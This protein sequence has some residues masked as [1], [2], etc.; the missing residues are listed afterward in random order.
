L[1]KLSSISQDARRQLGIA[2]ALITVIPALSIFY[3][4]FASQGNRNPAAP[5]LVMGIMSASIVL[6]YFLVTKYRDNLE[7]M[8][9]ERT[10]ELQAIND[11]LQLEVEERR[12]VERLKD[13]FVSTV[14]HELRTPLAI[15]R[16]GVSLLIDGIPGPINEKQAKVLT[17]AKGN[18]DRLTRIINDLLDISKIEAGRMDIKHER[19]GVDKLI[20]H[21]RVSL[22]PLAKQ[23]GLR[24]EVHVPEESVEVF[25]DED[26]LVQV[27]N[28]LISNAIKFTKEGGVTVSVSVDD[29][30]MR[31]VIEDT[32]TGISEDDM[33]RLFHKFVQI[34]R[35]HGAG[36]KG[37]GLG[38]VIAKNIVELHGGKIWVE[39]ELGKGT[40]FAFELPVYSEEQVLLGKIGDK[41]VN[42]RQMEREFSL[43]LWELRYETDPTLGEAK[44][45][46]L[47]RAIQHLLQTRAYLRST[48]SLELRGDRQ[49][50][51]L[52]EV[53]R[54]NAPVVMNRWRQIIEESLRD[55]A[56]AIHISLVCGMAVYPY[57]GAESHELLESAEK[58]LA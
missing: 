40:R 2:V 9:E 23:K 24:F 50:I 20:E 55:V 18:V 5:A 22:A 27:L 49:V 46:A 8:I 3:L 41:V 7:E 19:I 37:T 42:A 29:G 4:A 54:D 14:S 33:P 36:R 31:C 10:A 17:T 30:S 13:D 48:D 16:E 6:G 1:E 56:A 58:N 25:A 53:G 38:L 34:G 52:A 12:R 44:Q 11:Q 43:F 21:A 45:E 32:G 51:L 28:N 39:S 57:D 47:G 35:T 15:T 26:R